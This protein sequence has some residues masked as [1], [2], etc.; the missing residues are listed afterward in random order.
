MSTECRE[1]SCHRKATTIVESKHKNI[2]FIYYFCR[3]HW[4]KKLGVM[5]PEW[6]PN[7]A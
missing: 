5:Y 2:N 7:D 3:K 4:L 1:G 6:S